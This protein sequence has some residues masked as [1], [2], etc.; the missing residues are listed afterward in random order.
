MW[1]LCRLHE[2]W[3][4]MENNGEEQN[5]DWKWTKGGLMWNV[6]GFQ[7]DQWESGSVATVITD[8]FRK[9]W[10]MMP[11]KL[12][13]TVRII[14]EIEHIR[15]RGVTF[16]P[17]RIEQLF[18]TLWSSHEFGHKIGQISWL[19]HSMRNI[20]LILSGH[21]ITPPVCDIFYLHKYPHSF[22]QFSWLIIWFLH[23]ALVTAVATVS[24]LN[25]IYFTWSGQHVC[26]QCV[27]PMWIWQVGDCY[28]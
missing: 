2:Q 6:G 26:A 23:K 24:P 4:R 19:L 7:D 14:V 25:V 12:A 9:N 1:T 18:P 10:I 22:S 13:K 28:G 15:N 27:W 5:M 3:S 20:C 16:W 21:N 11:R 8:A 17:N